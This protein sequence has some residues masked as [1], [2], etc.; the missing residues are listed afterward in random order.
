MLL[1]FKKSCPVL[2]EL[3]RWFNLLFQLIN[4]FCTCELHEILFP[5]QCS[6]PISFG[7]SFSQKPFCCLSRLSGYSNEL[8]KMRS[9]KNRSICSV[10]PIN[11]RTQPALSCFS[12]LLK[13]AGARHKAW[14][15]V[16][17]LQLSDRN[18]ATETLKQPLMP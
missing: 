2:N 1:F 11:I 13:Q 10:A 15:T 4:F 14:L 5:F 6:P 7:I 3:F 16:P 12:F 8:K 9:W 18:T 17:T